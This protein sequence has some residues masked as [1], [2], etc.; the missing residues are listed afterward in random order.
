MRDSRTTLRIDNSP[1]TIWC[2]SPFEVESTVD[3]RSARVSFI[4]LHLQCIVIVVVSLLCWI[5]V[6]LGDDSMVMFLWVLNHLILQ[7]TMLCRE[8]NTI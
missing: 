4:S 6:S 1:E 8:E 3:T 7:S 5:M 2:C